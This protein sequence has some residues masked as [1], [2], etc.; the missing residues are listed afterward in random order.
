MSKLKTTTKGRKK[1]GVR[2]SNPMHPGSIL[3][4]Y[5]MTEM[6]LNQTQLAEKIGCSHRKVNE[7]V[8]GKRGITPDFAL[9]LE[10]VLGVSAEM[11]VNMQA[12]Y[13]LWVARQKKR[14]V[15]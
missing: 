9:D 4:S 6:N 3:S 10:R 13:D 8:N 5:Y 2:D 7:V 11:W 14:R 1:T 12:A 15:A